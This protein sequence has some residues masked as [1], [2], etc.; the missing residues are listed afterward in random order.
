M[1][2]DTLVKWQINASIKD[3][4]INSKNRPKHYKMLHFYIHYQNHCMENMV[5][6][7]SSSSK[8]GLVDHNQHVSISVS[9]DGVCTDG[10]NSN[11]PFNRRH[12]GWSP[13]F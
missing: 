1:N 8:R 9:A 10:N 4:V 11:M 5:S 2:A 7:T 3:V 12:Y 6:R 13:C